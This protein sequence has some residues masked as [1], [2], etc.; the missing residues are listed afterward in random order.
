MYPVQL[1]LDSGTPVIEKGQFISIARNIATSYLNFV[2]HYI[3][4]GIR[5]GSFCCR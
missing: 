1:L 2:I 4:T 3:S 5:F